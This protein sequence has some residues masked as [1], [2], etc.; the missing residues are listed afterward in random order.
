MGVDI[1]FMEGQTLCFGS[2]HEI[3]MGLESR[4]KLEGRL[5]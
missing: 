5:V 1:N 2:T 3:M 4:P